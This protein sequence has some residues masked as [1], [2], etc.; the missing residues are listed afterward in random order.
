MA[1]P[2]EVRQTIQ[3]RY[4]KYMSGRSL[5]LG[6]YPDFTRLTA[7]SSDERNDKIAAYAS[8]YPKKTQAL[9]R[10]TLHEAVYLNVS[11]QNHKIGAQRV[12]ETFKGSVPDDSK[13]TYISAIGRNAVGVT[14]LQAGEISRAIALRPTRLG[15][16]LEQVGLD[17]LIIDPDFGGGTMHEKG[18]VTPVAFS[19]NIPV[20]QGGSWLH[21]ITSQ[22]A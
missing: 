3:I 6:I 15:A 10:A 14:V 19:T 17:R 9:V 20:E 11:T 12:A 7:N 16:L 5:S 1:N 22:A 4:D 21:V 8:D 13:F 18:I 2:G